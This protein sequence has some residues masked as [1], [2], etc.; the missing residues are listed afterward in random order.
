MTT[1]R[2]KP[3]VLIGGV[4]KAIESGRDELKVTIKKWHR[5]NT[6]V[7]VS[8]KCMPL[9]CTVTVLSVKILLDEQ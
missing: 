4:P 7:S 6:R 3:Y 8:E 5:L 9:M 1:T 2:T